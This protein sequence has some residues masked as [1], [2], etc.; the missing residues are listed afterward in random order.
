MLERAWKLR[1]SI[2]LITSK[3]DR[4]YSSKLTSDEWDMISQIVNILKP[5][6]EA[7]NVLSSQQ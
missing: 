7:T 3:V 5:F 4:L 2:D 1:N 6:Y